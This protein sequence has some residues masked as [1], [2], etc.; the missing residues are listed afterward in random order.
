MSVIVDSIALPLLL[1]KVLHLADLVLVQLRVGHIEI[2]T[3]HD[4]ATAESA[5]LCEYK[6]LILSLR[7]S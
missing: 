3:E 6:L 1:T 4:T 7:T 5:L 2:L